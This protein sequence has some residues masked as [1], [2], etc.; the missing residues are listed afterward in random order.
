MAIKKDKVLKDAEKLVQKGKVEQAVREYEK[1]LKAYPEDTTT[2]NRVGDLYGRMGNVERAIELYEQIA[3]H[4]TKDGFNT[5][6]IAILKKINRLDPQRLHIFGRLGELYLEQGLTVEAKN[7]YR[8]LADW[9]LKNEDLDN[10]IESHQKLVDLEPDNHMSALRLADLL[11]QRGDA[12]AALDVYDRLGRMLIQAK[13]MD[14]AERLYRHVLDQDP[15]HGEFLVPVCEA[16]LDAGRAPVAREFLISA[17]NKSPESMV[18]KALAVRV[19]LVLGE[20][21]TAVELA[22]EVLAQD[23]DN[24]E[25]RTLVGGALLST[26]EAAEAREMLMP[27]C[28]DLLKKGDF[29]GA[30]KALQELLTAVPQDQQVLN[31][32]VRAFR[33]S[34]D[35]ETLFT[36]SAALAE[37][38]FRS[39]EQGG[40]RR[41]Y[42]ELLEHEP[43]SKLFRQRLAVLDGVEPGDVSLPGSEVEA[44]LDDVVEE[45]VVEPGEI[46]FVD[47]G[48]DPASATAEA[49]GEEVPAPV[50]FDPAERLAEANVFAKYGLVEKAIHHLEDI[51]RFYPEEMGAREKLAFLYIEQGD[52]E[53]AIGVA[54]PA[55]EHYRE[56][57][58]VDRMDALLAA[59]PELTEW[60]P[61]DER[62]EVLEAG[63]QIAAVADDEIEAAEPAV[64]DAEAVLQGSEADLPE[65][66]FVDEESDLVEIVDVEGDLEAVVEKDP[67]PL[68]EELIVDYQAEV[69]LFE[70]PS[71]DGGE[72]EPEPEAETAEEP[73]VAE[74]EEKTVDEAIGEL[75]APPPVMEEISDELFE[76]SDSF[77]G[78]SVGDLQQVDFFFEQELY[79]DAAR[80][81]IGL[82]EAHPE[83]AEVQARRLKLKEVGVLVEQVEPVEEGSE[84]LFADEEQ[85]ID[86][87]KE[88]EA[89]LAEEEAMVEE[90]TGRGKG[91]AL[92]EEVFREFQKGVAEQLS[93]EDS[94]T[95]FNLGIAY[96]EMGLLPEAIREFQVASRDPSYFVE[97]CSMIGVC[98]QDQGLWSEAAEWFQKALVAPDIS[99]DARIALRYDLAV[100]LESGGDTGQAVELF[101]EIEASAA[102]YRDVSQRLSVL[103][104]QRQAN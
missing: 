78:P 37:S 40:A 52:R 44:E 83:D 19:H 68:V 36:L 1:V 27:V 32:A 15:P 14:E 66:E 5:K 29:Q 17:T 3:D 7:Q 77:S 79:E 90:A 84:E 25:L 39:G 51:V 54:G 6:A 85:Y 92:L 93:E 76:I 13:K 69:D 16:L 58:N 82:E 73:V 103:A 88:L 4:F 45:I 48:L 56:Q 55:F 86:L 63:D 43:E 71:A 22:R 99:S 21:K 47:V 96:R 65:A 53:A 80:V 60:A 11:F 26:G 49:E 95:H 8:M 104:Q 100:A 35:Q 18:L 94:D 75:P 33:P 42:L 59:M 101:E 97:C 2:I 24:L 87:A 31:L 102:G 12:E 57:E 89:E 38:Y 50:V 72:R 67:E 70:L 74:T 34:G 41:L 10:A 20:A 91:E 28:E 23:S 9:Y 30:Q 46:E 61:D 62:T 98:Y 81:L 64:T